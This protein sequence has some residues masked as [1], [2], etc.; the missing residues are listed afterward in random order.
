MEYENRG[1]GIR[2]C[3]HALAVIL[4]AASVSLIIGA[5]VEGLWLD[6]VAAADDGGGSTVPIPPPDR[7]TPGDTDDSPLETTTFPSGPIT[8]TPAEGTTGE[9]GSG[10]SATLWVGI[11]LG[12]VGFVGVA[13]GAFILVSSRERRGGL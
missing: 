11:G 9:S 12:A 13:F 4:I 3:G 8:A 10:P 1:K 2:Q 6:Q 7:P 5:S